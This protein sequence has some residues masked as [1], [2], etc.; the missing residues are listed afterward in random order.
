MGSTDER[1]QR[2]LAV[3]TVGVLFF[4]LDGGIQDANA[5]FQRMTGYTR[6]ELRALPWQVLTPDEFIDVTRRAAHDLSTRGET[7]AYEKQMIRKDGSRWR[8]NLL[9]P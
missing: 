4:S 3:D 5:A 7:P 9:R 2:V 6:E 8:D 1:L